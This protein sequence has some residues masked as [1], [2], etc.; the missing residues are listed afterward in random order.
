MKEK[1]WV[2]ISDPHIHSYKAHDKDGSRLDNCQKVV[3]E[4]V[5]KADE[6]GGS[7]LN[8]GDWHD[9]DTLPAEVISASAGILNI[10]KSRGVSILSITGNHDMK[11]IPKFGSP[12]VSS[13][14]W[15]ELVAPDTFQIID[16]LIH[17]DRDHG[18][19]IY[20]IP[21]YDHL[22]E[23]S[24][25]L[26]NAVASMEAMDPDNKMFRLLLIHQTPE[27][28]GNAMIATDTDPE[29]PRYDAFDLILCGHIH[30]RQFITDKFVVV[31]SPIHRSREDA[32]QKKGTFILRTG[33][34]LKG[35]PA[36]ELLTFV[37]S[38]G[39]PEFRDV[40]AS[41]VHKEEAIEDGYVTIVPDL[42]M[43]KT[44]GTDTA[45]FRAN[46]KPTA[47]IE[48]YAEEVGG[49]LDKKTLLS[50]GLSLLS[51]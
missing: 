44:G 35:R 42:K 24:K 25:A 11:G 43:P 48:A 14:E 32:G 16:N 31:G 22:S 33:A 6:L 37:P 45:K 46:Q 8:V 29:D 50:T 21:Y 47:I 17:V 51:K 1:Q 10:A 5:L 23:Y 4:A 19:L 26:N 7:V 39:Y 12:I 27:G 36:K 34:H 15:M 38:E 20:G 2:V 40:K 9:K 41:E 13:I 49:D 18:T 30:Q 28:L 3:T